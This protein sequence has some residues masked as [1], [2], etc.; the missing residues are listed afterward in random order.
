MTVRK[1]HIAPA[2]VPGGLPYFPPAVGR[3]LVAVPASPR[4][5]LPVL[6][7]CG[8]SY[9]AAR[10]RS[11]GT[12]ALLAAAPD[13]PGAVVDVNR[14][15]RAIVSP[16]ALAGGAAATTASVDVIRAD[17]GR[18]HGSAELS[19]SRLRE[20]VDPRVED[21]GIRRTL[22]AVPP[23]PH[24]EKDRLGGRLCVV[25]DAAAVAS[26]RARAASARR[27]SSPA[28][29]LFTNPNMPADSRRPRPPPLAAVFTFEG[30]DRP[31][32]ARLVA[33]ATARGRAA[34]GATEGDTTVTSG[35]SPQ[36][37]LLFDAS[38]APGERGPTGRRTIA[39]SSRGG[40]TNNST[41]RRHYHT[42][43][44]RPAKRAA[45]TMYGDADRGVVE[46]AILDSRRCRAMCGQPVDFGA[47]CSLLR[48][49]AN[50]LS[51]AAPSS[52]G[53]QAADGDGM[54]GRGG[55]TVIGTNNF[56]A[57]SLKK[58]RHHADHHGDGGVAGVAAAERALDWVR[59]L[60]DADCRVLVAAPQEMRAVRAEAD[61]FQLTPRALRRR[62]DDVMG[63]SALARVSSEATE[64]P[65]DNVP[66]AHP[67]PAVAIE[68]GVLAAS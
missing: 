1:A 15:R 34:S 7:S 22:E 63:T 14:T 52:T 66:P 60:A 53:R 17:G 65:T 26:P 8:A 20:T 33:S 56:A 2:Y 9:S 64:P 46:R 6:S 47:A 18:V 39:S 12:P 5:E 28:E 36:P 59:Q 31:Y 37:P 10:A 49:A 29:H 13:E 4:C 24:G 19:T 30:Y 57:S 62:V 67:N 68:Q 32:A 54:G 55:G 45:A 42:A 58:A 3:K 23:Q 35:V 61:V 40:G 51:A 25:V 43:S 44:S 41:T 21:P 16:R 38:T 11:A 48:L 27:L 50:E